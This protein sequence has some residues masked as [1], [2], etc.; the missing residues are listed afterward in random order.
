MTARNAGAPAAF[1]HVVETLRGF[2]DAEPTRPSSVIEDMPAPER[3]APY[4]AAIMATVYR[5]DELSSPSAVSSS[6]TTP[7]ASAAGT[8]TSASSPTSAPTWSPRSPPT[9]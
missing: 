7:T 3:L 4:A 2:V 9:R 1:Q 6:C 8:A 5:E